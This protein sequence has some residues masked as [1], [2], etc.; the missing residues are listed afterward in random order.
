MTILFNTRNSLDKF[1]ILFCSRKFMIC[2]KMTF[3]EA[4]LTYMPP[5]LYLFMTFSSHTKIQ[6]L[7][8][9]KTLFCLSFFVALKSP[10]NLSIICHGYK[11]DNLDKFT[12]IT[13][14]FF[15]S[16][17]SQVPKM[18]CGLIAPFYRHLNK[19]YGE[20]RSIFFDI[21]I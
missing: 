5:S 18:N 10:R 13:K 8:N 2:R 17:S 7:N 20:K 12:T 3:E 1:N 9:F 16:H 21:I 15:Y 11:D 14:I 6:L 19:W 4:L